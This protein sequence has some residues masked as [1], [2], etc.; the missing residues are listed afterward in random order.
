MILPQSKG[1][2]YKRGFDAQQKGKGIKPKSLG[3]TLIECRL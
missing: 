1:E 3:A 2:A